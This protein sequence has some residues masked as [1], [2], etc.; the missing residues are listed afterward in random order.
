M[1]VDIHG[2]RNIC[3][4][5]QYLHFFRSQTGT[6]KDRSK[7]MPELMRSAFYAGVPCV[8]SPTHLELGFIHRFPVHTEKIP[9]WKIL[10]IGNKRIRNPYDSFPVFCLRRFH[11]DTGAVE[12]QCLCHGDYSDSEKMSDPYEHPKDRKLSAKPVI[13]HDDVWI[14]EMV[15]VL[16][17][18]EIGRGAIIGANSVV[19]KSVPEY[20]IVAGNPAKIIKRFDF[21]SMEWKRF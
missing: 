9:V 10:Q 19:T 18:V 14:G 13:I 11:F 21:E 20:S 16:P 5:H 8:F 2:S 12:L 7:L 1:F 4:T 3:V 6:D 15:S 17:G